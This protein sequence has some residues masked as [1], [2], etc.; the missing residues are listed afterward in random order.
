M[1]RLAS[2]AEE[3][4]LRRIDDAAQNF[5]ASTSRFFLDALN[6]NRLDLLN[7]ERRK[8]L[9]HFQ[10][11]RRNFSHA[12]PINLCDL[13]NLREDFFCRRDRAAT[14]RTVPHFLLENFL[15]QLPNRLE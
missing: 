8:L 2:F 9:A 3:R 15:T 10:T 13:V 12:A 5:A 4:T 11:R 7:I 6:R 1:E 14:K